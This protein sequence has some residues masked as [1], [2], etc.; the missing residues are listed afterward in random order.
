MQKSLLILIFV[1]ICSSGSGQFNEKPVKISHDLELQK[2]SDNAYVH[3]SYATLP[4]YGRVAANGLIFINRNEA[5]LFDTPWTDSLTEV[6]VT[7]LSDKMGL[8]VTGFIPNHW[9]EDCMGGLAYLKSK[10][11]PSYANQKTLDIARSK[12]LPVPEHGFTDS[13]NLFLGDK[14]IKCY[15][16][17]AAH[18][19]DNVVVWIPSEKILFPGCMIKSM[20]STDLGNTADGDLKTYPETIDWVIKRFMT[21]KI[22]IP[23][24]GNVGGPELLTHT[25]SLALKN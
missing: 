24:H 17:G 16:P 1:L 13:L 8:K 5:F 20:S 15:F 21:A 19:L 11:I 23:G 3:I 2:I 12:N 22:V 18:S 4:A 6:L 25:R 14:A 9:H 10:G 7:Y